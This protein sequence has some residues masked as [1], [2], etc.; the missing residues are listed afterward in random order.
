[1]TGYT[2]AVDAGLVEIASGGV[3]AESGAVGAT[4]VDEEEDAAGREGG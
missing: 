3:G 4:A 1:M 2:T